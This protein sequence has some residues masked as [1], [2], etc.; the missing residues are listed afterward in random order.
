MYNKIIFGK[1][2]HQQHR[3]RYH[4][5]TFHLVRLAVSGVHEHKPGQM[6][7]Q[8]QTSDQLEVDLSD[9]LACIILLSMFN[10]HTSVT[11]SLNDEI[12][13]HFHKKQKLT[14]HFRIVHQ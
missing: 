10:S 2:Q 1:N 12:N 4:T 3:V 6:T 11:I 9:S 14:R 8:Y 7:G 5:D 13:S